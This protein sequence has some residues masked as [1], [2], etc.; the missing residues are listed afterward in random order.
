MSSERAT[1]ALRIAFSAAAAVL[2]L[3]GGS[4]IVS[5]R[6][7]PEALLAVA[8][9][10][11]ALAAGALNL[12]W[13]L[14]APAGMAALA[15]ILVSVQLDVL[16]TGFLL[17]FAGL[18]LLGLGGYVG[19]VAYRSFSHA[20]E[21]QLGD[22]RSLSTQLEQ[23]HR[24]FV[25][26]TSDADARSAATPDIGA[27]TA[28]VAGQVGAD[29]ACYYLVSPD[30]RQFVPQP[31]GIGLDRLRPQAVNRGMTGAGPLISAV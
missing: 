20:M 5:G 9:G 8:A 24:A 21:R 13:K 12:A 28:N 2:I 18:L 19:S 25:A 6:E 15:T 7:G 30:G 23:K 3:A 1:F 26:A 17:Q 29:F 16:D 31:P 11:F 22:L 4:L 14:S 27:L 10:V